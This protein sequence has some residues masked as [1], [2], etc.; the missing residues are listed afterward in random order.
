MRPSVYVDERKLVELRWLGGSLDEITED[1][2]Y[3]L[4]RFICNKWPIVAIDRD[5][6]VQTSVFAMLNTLH[7]W[8]PERASFFNFATKVSRNAVITVK[9]QN[10]T[11]GNREHKVFQE[12]WAQERY[13]F[14]GTNDDHDAA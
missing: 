12:R 7:R 9:R 1:L 8:V 2:L 14:E 3:P 10:E 4:A 13:G 5:E 11:D 6:R